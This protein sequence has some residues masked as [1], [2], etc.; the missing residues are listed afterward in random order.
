MRLA[1]LYGTAEI[2]LLPRRN[3][4][5]SLLGECAQRH[6]VT[7]SEGEP[8]ASS[9]CTPHCVLTSDPLLAALTTKERRRNPV[10]GGERAIRNRRKRAGQPAREKAQQSSRA[11]LSC[12][13]SQPS[14]RAE[15]APTKDNTTRRLGEKSAA[16]RSPTAGPFVSEYLHPN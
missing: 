5:A 14:F 8:T 1:A 3:R 6:S 4:A 7:V 15:R 9:K 2:E 11:S 10:T 16:R 13:S 12:A